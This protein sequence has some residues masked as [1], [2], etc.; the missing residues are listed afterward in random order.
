MFCLKKTDSDLHFAQG[1]IFQAVIAVGFLVDFPFFYPCCD[2][3]VT[4]TKK[5]ISATICTTPNYFG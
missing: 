4:A 3:K 2:K 1:E 5:T